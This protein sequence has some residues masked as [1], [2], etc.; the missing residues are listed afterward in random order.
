MRSTRLAV[1]DLARGLAVVAM[2]IYHFSWDLSWFAYVDWPVAQ[3]SGWRIFA[4]SIAGSFLFLAGISLDFA[5]HKGIRWQAFWRRLVVIV[6]AAAAVSAVTYFTFGDTFV[7]FGILHCIAL[8]SLI[9][10]PF[11]RL[12]VFLAGLAAALVFSLPFWAVSPAFD[13]QVWLWTGLG[14]PGFASVD[15]VPLAPWAGVTLAGVAVSKIFRK[16]DL[17][18]K[19][20]GLTFSRP[21]G[22]LTRFLGRH[23]LAVYLLHQPL[24]YGLVWTATQIGPE[25]DRSANAFVRNC[26]VSCQGTTATPEICEAACGCTLDYLKADGIWDK[27]LAEPENQSLRN[28]MS[29][30]YSQ[31][32]ADPKGQAPLN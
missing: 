26:T 13:G 28:R 1:L 23:S 12:P 15:Y 2:A 9:A 4:A 24:L 27:L 5:H 7:R 22:R 3:G 19:V 21:P 14:T 20:S 18:Q 10:L 6:A 17:W 25:M 31:C 32:L 16:F 11:T 29:N 30:R 8:S